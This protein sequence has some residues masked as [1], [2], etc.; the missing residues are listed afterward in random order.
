MCI[1]LAFQPKG[2]E[3]RIILVLSIRSLYP[4]RV[5]SCLCC[6]VPSDDHRRVH[7]C[8]ELDDPW[9][10][11]WF[12]WSVAWVL[13]GCQQDLFS[14][15][16]RG[17]TEPGCHC[18]FQTSGDAC[19]GEQWGFQHWVPIPLCLKDGT[20]AGRLNL[21]QQSPHPL[22]LLP[23]DGGEGQV[24]E[25]WSISNCRNGCRNQVSGPPGSLSSA[26]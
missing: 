21:P 19:R 1:Y 16:L 25:V 15:W 26:F 24:W 18:S 22:A 4:L 6:C 14:S 12:G 20:Q 17:A 23:W 3:E 10:C 11:I 7:I 5:G 8:C 2:A 13:N 9:V